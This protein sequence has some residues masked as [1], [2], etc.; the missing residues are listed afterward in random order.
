MLSANIAVNTELLNVRPSVERGSLLRID[1]LSD[2]CSRGETSSKIKQMIE[3]MNNIQHSLHLYRKD[4]FERSAL[5]YAALK[6]RHSVVQ[7]LLDSRFDPN[8]A[9]I[10]G[11]FPLHLAI[12]SKQYETASILGRVSNRNLTNYRNENAIVLL[13]K[14]KYTGAS[15]LRLLSDLVVFGHSAHWADHRRCSALFYAVDKPLM[16]KQLIQYGV[17]VNHLDRFGRNALF[18][19]TYAM[20]LE[21]TELLIG[22]GS[23]IEKRD[24]FDH[25][26]LML[27][28]CFGGV[29]IADT[30]IRCGANI[31]CSMESASKDWRM[32]PLSLAIKHQNYGV[33][34]AL[35]AHGADMDIML[36]DDGTETVWDLFLLDRIVCLDLEETEAMAM[37]DMDMELYSLGDCVKSNP[38]ASVRK[39]I[40]D[41]PRH[42][43]KL[44]LRKF[45]ERKQIERKT[46]GLQSCELVQKMQIPEDILRLIASPL[47]WH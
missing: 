24:D 16:L 30:L 3:A 43:R 21:S 44:E 47:Y 4:S 41:N 17:D 5:H 25:T 31:D 36:N 23:E 2:A 19:A 35:V 28:A 33:A 7:L 45:M 46:K 32:C 8:E 14:N 9:D 40:I 15:M 39:E 18:N 27:A 6:C 22:A 1:A 11:D 38:S 34:H 13:S 20:N 42:Q 29:D 12:K 26:P 37:D 10:H